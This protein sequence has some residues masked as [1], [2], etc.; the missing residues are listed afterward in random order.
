[1]GSELCTSNVAA[2]TPI[3]VHFH[4]MC[5]VGNNEYLQR[6]EQLVSLLTRRQ[7]K[8]TAPQNK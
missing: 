6:G 3:E 7:E 8:E 4:G 2:V 5:S 1:M